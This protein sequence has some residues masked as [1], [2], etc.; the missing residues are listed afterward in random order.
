MNLGE[1]DLA[2]SL[3]AVNRLNM[4][5]QRLSADGRKQAQMHE[6][7]TQIMLECS[8][9]REITAPPLVKVKQG[10]LAKLFGNN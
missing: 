6:L 1:N 5:L 9:I 2:S 8:V 7:A 3:V 4:Q 10:W